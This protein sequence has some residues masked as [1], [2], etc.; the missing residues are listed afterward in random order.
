MSQQAISK[1][2]WSSWTFKPMTKIYFM[3]KKKVRF[4]ILILTRYLLLISVPKTFLDIISL[5]L[6]SLSVLLS[7]DIVISIKSLLT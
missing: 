3:T 2:A 6:W 4:V 1:E 7:I 5:R